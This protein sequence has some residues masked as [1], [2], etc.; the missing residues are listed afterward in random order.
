LS[1]FDMKNVVEKEDILAHAG[2]TEEEAKLP[3]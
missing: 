3:K 1:N 2:I